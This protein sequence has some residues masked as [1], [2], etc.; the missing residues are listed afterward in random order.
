MRASSNCFQCQKKSASPRQLKKYKRSRNFS[1]KKRRQLV[2][3]KYVKCRAVVDSVP[4]YLCRIYVR[5][6][7]PSIPPC[8]MI[9][10]IIKQQAE[11]IRSGLGTRSSQRKQNWKIGS[12]RLTLREEVLTKRRASPDGSS[13][14]AIGVL[15]YVRLITRLLAAGAGEEGYS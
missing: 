15:L 11:D 1:Q 10:I 14:V 5:K 12:S 4:I 3:S 2:S 13:L 8:V 9:M 6:C 7:F